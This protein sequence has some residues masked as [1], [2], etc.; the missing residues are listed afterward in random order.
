MHAL[1]ASLLFALALPHP[2]A[3]A[4]S[5]PLKVLIDQGKYWQAH[6]RGDLAGQAWKKVLGLDPNQPD[7]LF[8]MG[9]VLADRKDN[10]GAKRYLEQLRQTAPGFPQ[11]DELGQRLGESSP[12]NDEINDARRLAKMGQSA[13]AAQQYQRALQGAPSSPALRLEYY[14]ALAATPSGWNEARRGLEQLARDNPEDP[15]YA[16]AYA[17]HLTYRDATRRDGI[18]RL[19]QLAADGKVGAQARQSWRQALLWLAARPSDQARYVAYLKV[20]PDDPPVKARYDSMVRQDEADRERG[21]QDA[22]NEVRGREIADGFAALDRGD[23]DTARARFN[24]ILEKSPGNTDALGGLGIVELKQERFAQARSD[25]ERASRGGNA[26]RWRSALDSATYWTYTSEALGAQSNGD[27]AKAKALFERAILA[28]PSNVTAQVMLGDALLANR[29]PR[30]AEQAYRMALRRQ[31]DHPD[32]LRGLVGA[33]AAQGRGDEALQF[34]QQLTAEQ[35]AKAGG[36]DRLR[37]TAEAAQARE[38]DARGDLG[39]ARSLF[40]DALAGTPN[41]PW[42]RLDLARVYVRQG[43][44]ASARSMMDGLLAEH[45]DMPDALYASALLAEQ[46]HDWSIGLQRL[47]RVPAEQRTAA[48]TT[49]QHR[50]W[51]G[52]QVALATRMAQH[53]QRAQAIGVLRETEA[54][55]QE[56][57][58]LA[59]QLSAGYLA[60]GDTSRA[61]GL[62]QRALAREPGNAGLLLQ[63]ARILLAGRQDSL[64]GDAMRRLAA[65]QLTPQ[66]RSDFDALNLEIVV[67]QADAVR[68]R[69]DLAGGYAVIAPWLAAMPDSPELQAALARLYASAGDSANALTC[70]RIALARRPDDPGLLIAAIY[71][72]SG[73]KAWRD[74]EAFAAT[75]LR[76]SPDDPALLAAIGRLYRAEGQLSLAAQYL[77]RS[78]VAGNTPPVRSTAS[79]RSNVPRGWEAAMQRIGA[80]PLPG[81]NPFEGKTSVDAVRSAGDAGAMVPLPGTPSWSNPSSSSSSAPIVPY[82]MPPA[83]PATYMTPA[84]A[85]QSRAPV[86]YGAALAADGDF[87]DSSGYGQAAGGAAEAGGPATGRRYARY[88]PAAADAQQMVPPAGYVV[89]G[90]EAGGGDSGY[91][92]TPWPMSPAARAAQPSAALAPATRAR[93]ARSSRVAR[94][95]PNSYQSSSANSSDMQ[96]TGRPPAYGQ[97]YEWQADDQQ[98]AYAQPMARQPGYGRQ[99]RA[100]PSYPQQPYPS[101]GYGQAYAQQPYIPQPPAGYAQSYAAAGPVQRGANADANAQTLGVA[102]E[103]AQ[104]NRDQA[105]TVTGGLVF[106]NRTGEDGLSGLTDIETPIEGRIKA[107]NGHVVVTATPVMLDAGTPAATDVPTRARYG[108][109]LTPASLNGAPGSQSASGVGLSVGYEGKQLKAD[110]GATPIGFPYQNVVGGVRYDGAMT[111]RASYSLAVT[112]RAVTDSLLSFAGAR[113]SGSGLKWGGVTRSGVRGAL[114]WDDG[115]SGLYVAGSFDYYDGHHVERNFSGKGGGGAYTRLFRDADQTLTVGVNATWMRFSQNQSYFTYGQG[116]YFSPQQYVILNIPIEYAGR[117]GAFTYDLTGSIGVQHYRQNEAPYFPLD[118]DMQADAVTNIKNF[119]T[120]QLDPGAV[121]PARSKTGV[122]YSLAARGEYQVASQLAVGATASFGNAYQYREWVAAIYLRY[123]F[124]P[125]SGVQPFPPRIFTTPY[126]ADSN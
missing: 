19:E 32:A 17:Q 43:A 1:V 6:G 47:E 76:I 15:R 48:M 99:M 107:G 3:A 22:A 39:T 20:V 111:D 124:T 23:L 55:G 9:M 119:P 87:S 27:F 95:G 8:G 49:L 90:D 45:P 44:I 64:L 57:P 69:G 79:A 117:A 82:S 18:A 96:P 101:D 123:S 16:L 93:S 38:A 62:V 24:A 81:T 14:Q 56:A 66:Q 7:A 51:V 25:L 85:P 77:Q 54:I 58:A 102:A 46:T 80:N 30:G 61:L 86:P 75:A 72:A 28:D 11:I 116:G 5:D 41:D 52:Q 13:S 120:A 112:R 94:G 100:Q 121:Y 26:A 33:L 108:A 21:Q 78:L 74:G 37:R 115:T 89:P 67:R 29:D 35:Q 110:I 98:P 106:R 50:L 53:G 118:P 73:A 34:A 10:A 109:G 103:L 113:D 12:R 31:S 83:P 60:A 91:V 126:L 88:L 92:S 59:V 84:V 71:A 36:F 114:G 40:E 42:L 97:A 122:A 68:Q 65:M 63:Y 4:G 104:V 125:Q 2:A 70:Y 105:S